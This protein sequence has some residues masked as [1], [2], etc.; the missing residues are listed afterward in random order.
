MEFAAPKSLWI[1]VITAVLALGFITLCAVIFRDDEDRTAVVFPIAILLLVFGLSYYYSI[2]KY[3]VLSD[4]IIVQR[5]FD[6]V[7]IPT[8]GLTGRRI[9]KKDIRQSIRT[10]GIGGVF[11]Y[12]GTFWN[13]KFGSMTWYVTDMDK[14]VLLTDSRSNK[15]IVSP[16]DAEKFIAALQT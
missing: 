1:K 12:T 9:E 5:P 3:K 13:S 2:V 10:F 8:S 11:A 6:S 14:A 7:S 4:K 16:D 15:T